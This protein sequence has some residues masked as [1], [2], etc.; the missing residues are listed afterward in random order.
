VTFCS[1]GIV[2][3]TF[4]VL[5][6]ISARL[7]TAQGPPN[8]ADNHR[9]VVDQFFFAPRWPDKASYYTGEMK[10]QYA[11]EK[12]MGEFGAHARRS[13]LRVLSTT[14]NEAVY[15]VQVTQGRRAQNWYA[16]MTKEGNSWRLAAV[17]TL[18]LRRPFFMLLDSLEVTRSL[19][20]S[21]RQMLENMRLTTST[22]S[23]LKAFFAAIADGF[24]RDSAHS[25]AAAPVGLKAPT[26]VLRSLARQLAALHFRGAWRD[27]EHP[28]CVFLEIGG[29]IDNEVGFMRCGPGATPP[30]M[31]PRQFILVEVIAPGWYLYKTT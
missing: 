14:S 1:G 27:T 21:A 16:Y 19:A 6:L 5:L 15:T 4:S 7:A 22:D 12:S 20:D 3:P 10:A 24:A 9:W 30:S 28:G 11:D 2:R 26:P 13:T 31:T 8:A 23:A 29:M 17:R 18:A 25:I